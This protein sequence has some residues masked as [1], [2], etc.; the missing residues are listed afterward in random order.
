MAKFI[1]TL[2]SRQLFNAVTLGLAE[3]QLSADLSTLGSDARTAKPALIDSAK[4]FAA[5]LKAL[6]LKN[7]PLKSALNSD[8]NAARTK[9]TGDVTHIISAGVA[10][11]KAIVSAVLHITILD[12][13]NTTKIARDQKKLASN[14]TTLTNVET[15]LIDKLGGDITIQSNKIATAVSAIVIADSSDQALQT[16]WTTL[17]NVFQNDAQILV[18]D[19]NHVVTDLNN[20]SAAM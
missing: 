2:E 12:G 16:D 8:I 9:L 11:A 15:P 19:L 6:A 13:G 7:S 14:I 4:T 10:N 1:E 18:P 3:A 5:D 20:L 17:S